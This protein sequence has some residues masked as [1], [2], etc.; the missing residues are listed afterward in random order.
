[1]ITPEL[2]SYIRG[3]LGKGRKREEIRESLVR[4]GGWSDA[5]LS[6]AFRI[7]M[8]MQGLEGIAP[9]TKAEPL[10]TVSTLS[11]FPWKKISMITAIV[12]VVGGLVFAGWFYRASLMN[13]WNSGVSKVKGFSVSLFGPKTTANTAN[14]LPTPPPIPPQVPQNNSTAVKPIV[15]IRD[16]GIGIAPDMKKPATYQNDGVL[17][18]LGNSAFNCID[19]KAVLNDVLFP[20]VVQIIKTETGCNFKLSYAADS[21]LV[22]ATEAKL[23]GQYISCP[24]SIVKSVDESKKVAVFN[25]PSTDNLSKYAG[26]IYFYGTLG[27]FMETNLDRNKIQSFGCSGFYIDS[28]IA[29]FRKMQEKR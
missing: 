20:T 18:C 3:E 21:T 10:K 26:Q 8:P 29:S 16:C 28:V 5:D 15:S 24:L 25:F 22:D 19:A 1:M 13:F 17:T 23:S 27:V 7:V 9:I 12:L 11:T 6:E 2:I 4:E 14:T